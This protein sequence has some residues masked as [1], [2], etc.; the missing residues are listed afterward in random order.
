MFRSSSRVVATVLALALAPSCGT[1]R[2][3]RAWRQHRADAPVASAKE[4]ERDAQTERMRAA[5]A[6]AWE[7]VAAN[8]RAE[9]YGIADALALSKAAR[10]LDADESWDRAPIPGRAT[11]AELPRAAWWYVFTPPPAWRR[12]P[13]AT[14]VERLPGHYAAQM[15]LMEHVIATANLD[16]PLTI[17]D[18]A[19]LH[20]IGT[21]GVFER[22]PKTPLVPSFA[23]QP[24]RFTVAALHDLGT[25]HPEHLAQALG[26][27]KAEGVAGW[28][29]E[30]DAPPDWLAK[31]LADRADVNP[32]NK[33][34][35][36]A[37]ARGRGEGAVEE[38][39]V[40][41]N[42][43]GAREAENW[44]AQWLR[45]YADE[46]AKA[47]RRTSSEYFELLAAGT[48]EELAAALRPIAKLVRRLRV[49][50]V[51]CDR[52]DA[53]DALLLNYLLAASGLP[54]TI[55]EDPAMFG[56]REPL[57]RLVAAIVTGQQRFQTLARE[58]AGR[59]TVTPA[60]AQ[61]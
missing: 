17:D 32:Y 24:N 42:A 50:H 60:Q 18:Y 3:F 37:Y 23:K 56:G 25:F 27:L 43:Y 40:G 33:P 5:R 21:L 38:W 36:L 54:P 31:L 16:A 14:D 9:G 19:E 39:L 34:V 20:R 35:Q 58:L 10:E 12:G 53:I 49:S 13:L 15:D 47:P 45:D 4:P 59:E 26:E 2:D 57:D 44:A 30:R 29:A 22:A 8:G 51:F 48:T 52:V 55:V 6:R 46:R 7:G 61:Q 1:I 41:S 11:L 28:N